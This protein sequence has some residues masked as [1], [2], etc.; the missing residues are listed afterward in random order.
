[1]ADSAYES[2]NDSVHDLHAKGFDD[3]SNTNYSCLSTQTSLNQLKNIKYHLVQ[4]IVHEI[5]S[6]FLRRIAHVEGT[7]RQK[8]EAGQIMHSFVCDNG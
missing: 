5:V 8:K 7:Y 2:L 6:L 3:P 4:E 1:V